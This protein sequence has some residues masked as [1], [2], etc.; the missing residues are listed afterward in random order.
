MQL[1]K[2][3]RYYLIWPADD[4]IQSAHVHAK[5]VEQLTIV[6]YHEKRCKQVAHSLNVA[7]I[8]IFPNVPASHT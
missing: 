2:K 6:K 8:Q 4:V 3:K 5:S 7:N 1:H